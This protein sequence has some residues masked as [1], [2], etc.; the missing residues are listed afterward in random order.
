MLTLT[1]TSTY[2]FP[3]LVALDAGALLQAGQHHD[4]RAPLLPDQPP[5]VG[6]RF[7]QRSLQNGC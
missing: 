7:R 2:K 4:G 3:S 6:K 1:M 5:K